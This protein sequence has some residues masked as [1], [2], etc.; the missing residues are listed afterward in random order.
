LLGENRPYN[1]IE[2]EPMTLKLLLL[3][4]IISA[5]AAADQGGLLLKKRGPG[6]GRVCVTYSPD[7]DCEMDDAGN[8]TNVDLNQYI[9][10]RATPE[11][12]SVFVKWIGQCQGQQQTCRLLTPKTKSKKSILAAAVFAK[13]PV[14]RPTNPAPASLTASKPTLRSTPDRS[15]SSLAL[16]VI[17]TDKTNPKTAP[18]K[19]RKPA[20]VIKKETAQ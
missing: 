19:T 8:E 20:A 1:L 18:A 6:S 2:G 14:R 4:F 15:V 11:P 3:L 13:A 17:L 12:G 7:L 9:N 5:E 10:L 16:P